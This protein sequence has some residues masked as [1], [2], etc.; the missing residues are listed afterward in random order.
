MGGANNNM[1]KIAIKG[2]IDQ[3]LKI[4]ISS[5]IKKAI[6][7]STNTMF[8]AFVLNIKF[9]LFL[10]IFCLYLLYQSILFVV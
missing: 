1:P 3:L 9:P 4:E 8:P 6:M 2:V 5:K 7:L 10:I